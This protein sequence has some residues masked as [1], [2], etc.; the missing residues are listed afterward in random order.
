MESG[1]SSIALVCPLRQVPGVG[2][3]GISVCQL[4]VPGTVTVAGQSFTEPALLDTGTVG[5][6]T[7]VPVAN[8]A[9]FPSPVSM[10]TALTPT[11]P[12][13]FVYG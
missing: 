5:S 2:A 3:S 12:S 11:L 10:G 8:S 4:E 13:G 7:N 1:F 9:G 6:I